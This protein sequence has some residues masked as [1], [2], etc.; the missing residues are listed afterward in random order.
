MLNIL[1][2]WLRK[3]KPALPSKRDV[4]YRSFDN[5]KHNAKTFAE[6]NFLSNEEQGHLVSAVFSG[7]GGK[8]FQLNSD[9]DGGILIYY[10]KLAAAL[11]AGQYRMEEIKGLPVTGQTYLQIG[12][13]IYLGVEVLH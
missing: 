9:A 2:E 13:I 8:V 4:R 7:D 3:P 1:P 10:H 12:N 11:P 6:L 5:T